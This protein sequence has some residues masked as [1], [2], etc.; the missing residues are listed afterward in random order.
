MKDAI[1]LEF[2][3]RLEA[4]A[5]DQQVVDESAEARIP[6]AIDKGA[7]L[8]MRDCAAKLRKLVEILGDAE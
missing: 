3:S 6:N 7:R 4:E 2:A 8:A 5:Q 1:L